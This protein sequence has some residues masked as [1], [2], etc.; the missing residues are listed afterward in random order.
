MA[1]DDRFAFAPVHEQASL[2]A[3]GD[4]SP[5]ELTE[6]YLE[7]IDVYDD[8]LGAYMA[9]SAERALAMA[10]SAE[11][12]IV[13][14]SYRGPLHGIPLALKDLID[15]DGLPTTAGSLVLRDDVASRDATVARKLFEAGAVLLG[16]T[17][18]VEFAFGGVGINHHY[19]TPWNPWDV[20]VQR[21]PGG[22]SSGSAVA[23]AAG[24][25]AIAVGS[26][27]G[28]SVRIPA[29]F[30]GLVGLKPTYGRISSAGVVPLDP[31]LD[32][33]GPMARCVTDAALLYRILAGPDP[34][35]PATLRQP[36]LA[37]VDIE[38]EV[39]GTRVCIPRE[40]FWD[41]VDPEV[42][43]AVRATVQ[44][45]AELGVYVDEISLEELDRLAELRAAKNLTAVHTYATLGEHLESRLHDFDPIVSARMLDGRDVS[46]VEYVRIS[47][48]WDDLRA[49]THEALRDVDALLVPTTPFP[50]LPVDD[51]DDEGDR[52]WRTNGMCLR[53][54]GAANL[55]GLCAISLPCGFTRAGLP[56]GLMLIGRPFE[57]D[58]LLRL[59]HS[60]ETAT[61]WSDQHPDLSGF[62]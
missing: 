43:A 10:R 5:V 52:Y 21:I 25:A 53:N 11:A 23:A 6:L 31:R 18:L 57:E 32:S 39:A 28:G 41:D 56:V 30:C 17:H 14:G 29:S 62:E 24:L 37:D 27:T 51:C 3:R 19:G 47:R 35:D 55:L 34:E 50:A 1:L 36:P 26:D 40:Y 7:R 15:V 58:R 9:V 38:G 33:V 46:A 60:Y 44:V 4:I 59:A 48:A 13:G 20:E 12:A 42:E 45:F 2:I 22:S 16:K 54:T 61:D 49:R 8:T